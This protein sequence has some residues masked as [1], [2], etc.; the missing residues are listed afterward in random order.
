MHEAYDIFKFEPLMCNKGK[1]HSKTE[2]PIAKE[3]EPH[4]IHE[5]RSDMSLCTLKKPLEGNQ[6]AMGPDSALSYE[7]ICKGMPNLCWAQP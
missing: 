5:C 7:G 4:G 1:P 3:S 2:I 6:W